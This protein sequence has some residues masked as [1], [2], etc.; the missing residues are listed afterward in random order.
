[1]ALTLADLSE[2]IAPRR[3]VLCEGGRADTGA[4]KAEFDAQCYQRIFEE[5]FPDTLFISV[6]AS[7]DIL[8]GGAA[9][10]SIIR[11]M[12]RG[13]DVVTLIDRDERTDAEV[14]DAERAGHRVLPLRHI[15]HYLLA[16]EVLSKLCHDSGKPEEAVN[17]L[18]EKAQVIASVTMQGFAPDDIKKVKGSIYNLVMARLKNTGFKL[19]SNKD[20]FCRDVLAP[21]I[22]PGMQIYNDLK[23][24]IFD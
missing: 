4:K 18:A 8:T 22:V 19:G 12:A 17:V 1:M 11:R 9:L 21:R 3:V 14:K 5:E 15:E 24:A 7:N 10:R 20:A 13:V 23:S 16:D 2:L 6:G